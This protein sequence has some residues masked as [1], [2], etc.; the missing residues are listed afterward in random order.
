MVYKLFFLSM[1]SITLINLNSKYTPI[2]V[3]ICLYDPHSAKIR[4][5]VENK[6]EVKVHH[7]L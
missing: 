5:M 6:I 3:L 7:Q 2:N 4:D 1:E